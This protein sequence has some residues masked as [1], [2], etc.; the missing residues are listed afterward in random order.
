LI[1]VALAAITLLPVAADHAEV[2]VEQDDDGTALVTVETDDGTAENA[3]VEVAVDDENATYDGA[4]E[5]TADENGTVD[6]PAPNGTV[7][8]T[9]TATVGNETVS[10]SA[11][12]GDDPD[13]F[14]LEVRD[15]VFSLNE[16]D[17]PPGLTIS[18][19][20]VEN[21]PGDAPD[22]AGPPSVADVLNGTGPPTEAG[23]PADAGPDGDSEDDEGDDENEDDGDDEDEDAGPPEDAGQSGSE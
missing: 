18:A 14:G 15:F 16:T 6:L 4:G 2:E 10:E 21:N 13:A 9:V 23:L 22:D 20:V 19:F 7:N 1:A 3:S 8:V 11:T 12:L 17:G 5:Y